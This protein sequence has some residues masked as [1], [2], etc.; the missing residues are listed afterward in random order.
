MR[1]RTADFPDNGVSENTQHYCWPGPDQLI[2]NMP[3]YKRG[4]PKY[5]FLADCL[6]FLIGIGRCPVHCQHC[7]PITRKLLTR[8]L[9]D[10]REFAEWCATLLSKPWHQ[11]WTYMFTCYCSGGPRGS[12]GSLLIFGEKHFFK[13]DSPRKM[14]FR[15]THTQGPLLPR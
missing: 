5:R 8:K 7:R 11:K 3:V 15:C 13:N 14:F 2:P 1:K 9:T 4:D 10:N 12:P 6:S